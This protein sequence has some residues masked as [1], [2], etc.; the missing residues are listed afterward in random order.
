MLRCETN[1]ETVMN[2]VRTAF[3][4]SFPVHGR[5]SVDFE[6]GQW[7][8]TCSN[9][10]AQWSVHDADGDKFDFEQVSDGDEFCETF[11]MKESPVNKVEKSPYNDHPSWGFCV[12]VDLAVR[13]QE[14]W[15]YEG[16]ELEPIAVASSFA[17][18]VVICNAVNRLRDGKLL[19]P[20]VIKETV[21]LAA[22]LY[23]DEQIQQLTQGL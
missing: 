8:V 3:E 14:V 20:A 23:T 6:H 1:T 22:S 18:A 21:I 2:D 12:D 17:E 7:W 19:D 9:C 11:N 4:E 15:I 16:E 13:E 10:G 5:I